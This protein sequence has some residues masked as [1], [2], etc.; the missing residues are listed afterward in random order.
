MDVRPLQERK[1]RENKSPDLCALRRKRDRERKQVKR[2]AETAE[3]HE[4]RL[5]K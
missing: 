1:S 2:A 3:Q 5:R 4:K